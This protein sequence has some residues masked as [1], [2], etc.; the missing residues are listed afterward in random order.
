LIVKFTAPPQAVTLD[1]AN[2]V[3]PRGEQMKRA[4]GSL[5]FLVCRK[6]AISPD[7]TC[8]ICQRR[9]QH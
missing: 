3:L 4:H 1:A 8:L 2:V 5:E 6:P 9:D 7:A